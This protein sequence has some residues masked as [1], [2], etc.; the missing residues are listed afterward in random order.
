M[1]SL[2]SLQSKKA[3]EVCEKVL[4]PVRSFQK[5]NSLMQRSTEII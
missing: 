3:G 4:I 1:R 2:K 5:L